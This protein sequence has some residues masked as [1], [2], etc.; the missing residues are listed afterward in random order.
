VEPHVANRAVEREMRELCARLEAMEAMQREENLMLETSVKWKVRRHKLK[1][2]QG[3]ML[4][5]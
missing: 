5:E 4:S 2:L 1:K 3:E